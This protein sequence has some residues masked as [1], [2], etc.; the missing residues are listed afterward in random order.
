MRAEPKLTFALTIGTTALQHALSEKG[1]KEVTDGHR[2]AGDGLCARSSRHG[3]FNLSHPNTIINS[4]RHLPQKR[5]T[6]CRYL[7]N[8]LL[9][10]RLT[11]RRERGFQIVHDALKAVALHYLRLMAAQQAE[12]HFKDHR[13]PLG[14]YKV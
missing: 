12:G 1:V 2:Q 13:R 11:E 9:H 3:T 4:N 6:S 7:H 14:E 8:G 10:L 5:C